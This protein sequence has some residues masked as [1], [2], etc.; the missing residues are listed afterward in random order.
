MT[1]EFYVFLESPETFAH[2]VFPD[3]NECFV[4]INTQLGEPFAVIS[5]CLS[6]VV[7]R[8]FHIIHFIACYGC[9]DKGFRELL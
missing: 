8:P 3:K 6:Y 4:T 7:I 9:I 5:I 1:I 2:I